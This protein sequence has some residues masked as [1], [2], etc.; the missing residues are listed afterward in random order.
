MRIVLKREEEIFIQTVRKFVKTELEPISAQVE[1]EDRIPEEIISK[2]R[3]LG[4]F[5]MSVPE[6]YGGFGF[7]VTGQ[8]AVM[9]EMGRTNACFRTIISTN[10]GI[11]VTGLVLAGTP[12]QKEKYLP[13]IATGEY[14]TA[15]ALTEPGAGSDAAGIKTSAVR[16][17]DNYVL[18]GTKQFIT[19]ADVASLFSVI[20]VTDR[21]KKHDGLTMFLVERGTPGF[22]VGPPEKKMGLRGSHTCELFFDDCRV[23]AGN[24]VGG[25][26]KGFRLAMEVLDK[27]RLIIAASAL[28]AA[29]KLLEMMV[30]HANQRVAFGK[31]IGSFQAIQ[32]MIA[33]SAV[34]IYAMENMIYSAA[35]EMDEGKKIP[36]RV[37]MAKLFATEKACE[38]ADRALQVHGGMGY[39]KDLPV[40]RFY[41]DLRLTR[42]YEG[43]SEIQ[44]LIIARHCLKKGG[45]C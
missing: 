23:P 36:H 38:I 8:C 11:G 7:S 2:M 24:V 43:T 39:M 10:N 32:W 5:G 40:E 27:G 33:D 22:T 30:E 14:I 25:E 45:E 12:E 13:K 9:E 35:A 17:G 3:Q 31:P 19:N 15:F 4:L 18:N 26:G 16:A 29:R 20:A 37:A 1:E 28:G 41:R 42:I 44:R 21:E 34:E 6:E